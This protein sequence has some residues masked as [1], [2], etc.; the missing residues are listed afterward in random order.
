MVASKRCRLRPAA[1]WT[2]GEKLNPS[3][4]QATLARKHWAKLTQC[5]RRPPT[6]WSRK[7]PEIRQSWGAFDACV[8]ILLERAW[9]LVERR[10][11]A[12]GRSRPLFRFA[13]D[14]GGRSPLRGAQVALP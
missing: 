6:V 12:A 2:E 4:A 3:K 14:A 7:A 9:R 1:G 10:T 13:A 5:L 11:A 8:A